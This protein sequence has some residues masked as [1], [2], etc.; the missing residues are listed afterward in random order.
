MASDADRTGMIQVEL[1]KDELDKR[2]AK[3]AREEVEYNELLEKKRSHN[4][5]WNE[6]LRQAEERIAVLAQEVDSGKAWVPAQTD[7]FGGGEGSEEP[8][9]EDEEPIEPARKRRTRRTA[10]ANVNGFGDVA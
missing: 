10:V 7:M 4:R 6:Q 8:E 1:S 5:E 2:S 3:L 9:A